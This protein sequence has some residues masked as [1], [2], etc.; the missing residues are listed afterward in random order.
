MQKFRGPVKTAVVPTSSIVFDLCTR[1][2][3]GFRNRSDSG[4]IDASR[5]FT[6]SEFKMSL[7]DVVADRLRVAVPL[8]SSPLR[9]E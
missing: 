5:Y 1:T 9:P 6:V 4:G 2:S 7:P 3:S 8:A